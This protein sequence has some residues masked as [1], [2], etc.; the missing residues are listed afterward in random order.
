VKIGSVLPIQEYVKEFCSDWY[1][2]EEAT[3]IASNPSRD[4]TR[5]PELRLTHATNGLAVQFAFAKY[6]QQQGFE[7]TLNFNRKDWWYDFIANGIYIDVKSRW[8]GKYFEQSQK[9][10]EHLKRTGAQVLYVCID[11]MPDG[12]FIHRG[13]CWGADLHP[14]SFGKPFATSENLRDIHH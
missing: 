14:S 11:A 3:R 9:E 13:E 6:L 5:S 7:I 2:L 10:C 1:V 12:S 4:D 8:D